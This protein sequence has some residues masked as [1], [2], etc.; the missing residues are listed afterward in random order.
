MLGNWFPAACETLIIIYLF[1][2]KNLNK[3]QW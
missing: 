1:T 2:G 3:L